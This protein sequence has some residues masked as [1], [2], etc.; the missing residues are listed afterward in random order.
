MKYLIFGGT[1]FVGRTLADHIKRSGDEVKVVSRSN[2][3]SDF[4]VDITDP[5]AL[6]RIEY[7]PDVIINCASRLPE[8]NKTSQDPQFVKELFTT[9]VLGGL[10]VANWAIEHEIPKIINCSTLVVTSKPWPVPL[11]EE[12]GKVPEGPHVGYAMSKLSQEKIMTEAVRGTSTNVVHARLSAVYGSEMVPEGIIFSLMN[13]FKQNN[14][15]RLFDSKE[16]YLDLVHVSTVA[17]CLYKLSKANS[18]NSEIINIAS[19]AEISV[20]Q[21]AVLLKKITN[22]DSEIINENPK[23]RI[24]RAKIS[25]DRLADYT[26]IRKENFLPLEEGLT[27][28]INHQYK[29]K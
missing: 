14:A 3:E 11:L 28:L 20:Y 23:N 16:S 29:V 12:E 19:G 26:G 15:V 2:R 10:N 4:L 17:A 27:Q 18:W 21:L 1:G 22:S 9:N 25:I 24:S 5:T 7:V 13:D 6:G 8:K